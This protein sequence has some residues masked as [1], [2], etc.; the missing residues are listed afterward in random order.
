MRRSTKKLRSNLLYASLRRTEFRAGRDPYLLLPF[1]SEA[2]EIPDT[3]KLTLVIA[4]PEMV[5]PG[6]QATRER[7]SEWTRQRG[8]SPRLY[9]GALVWVPQE[10]P[11]ENLHAREVEL[12]L[13]WRR[14][15][16]EVTEGTLGGEFERSDRAELQAKVKESEGAA[17][18]RGLG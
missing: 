1:P 14:V 12:M 15:A 13:A 18:G 3:P 5:W 17:K 16:F 4:D 7:I 11:A 8:K 10:A 2:S 6:V 9:P